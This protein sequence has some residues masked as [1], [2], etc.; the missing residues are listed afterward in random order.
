[1]TV[2]GSDDDNP[3]FSPDGKTFYF[4]SN[5]G[6]AVET[7]SKV[8]TGRDIWRATITDDIVSVDITKPAAK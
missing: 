3:C 7:S 2:N 1:M 5:R 8:G 4:S 6:H